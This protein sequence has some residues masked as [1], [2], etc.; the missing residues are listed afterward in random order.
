LTA[1]ADAK[2]SFAPSPHLTFALKFAKKIMKTLA[3]IGD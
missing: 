1:G 3:L 2:K